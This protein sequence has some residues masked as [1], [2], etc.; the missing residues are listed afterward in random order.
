MD[1]HF[2]N[3]SMQYI[4]NSKMYFPAM[5]IMSRRNGDDLVNNEPAGRVIYQINI[6][7]E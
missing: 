7:P 3:R 1:I 5:K 6:I 4:E 2:F